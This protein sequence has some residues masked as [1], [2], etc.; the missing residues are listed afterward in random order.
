MD[1]ETKL[2]P[3]F[4]VGKRTYK[5]AESFIRDLQYRII[6]RF[7]L[8][9]DSFKP[10]FN[11]VDNVFGIDI[12]YGQIH[13]EYREE[14]KSEK[15]YSPAQIV[16]VII[17]PLIGQLRKNNISTSYIERQNL[18]IRMH[19]RRFTRLTNAFS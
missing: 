14:T 7:Q 9:T 13:K 15:R 17:N 2:I 16:R 8:S 6:T 4:R 11:A 5:V 12:D 10:F 1:A 18:T 19:M 3:A